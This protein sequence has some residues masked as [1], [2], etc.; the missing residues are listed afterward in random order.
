MFPKSRQRVRAIRRRRRRKRRGLCV[1][2]FFC[3][4]CAFETR[5][6]RTKSKQSREYRTA[7]IWRTLNDLP[8]RPFRRDTLIN[9]LTHTHT[10]SFVRVLSSQ[11]LAFIIYHSRVRARAHT[12]TPKHVRCYPGPFIKR[13]PALRCMF[14]CAKKSNT[15]GGVGVWTAEWRSCWRY[16][17]DG[18]DAPTATT[19]ALKYKHIH[20][21]LVH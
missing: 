12:H 1:S 2:A 13:S 17:G 7:L 19:H 18:C 14:V 15:V 4:P 21:A 3:N 8:T 10:F 11:I 20:N 5:N 16:E 9:T 6:T